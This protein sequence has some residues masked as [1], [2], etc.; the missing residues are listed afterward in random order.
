MDHSIGTITRVVISE[1]TQE[2]LD[3]LLAR[4]PGLGRALRWDS[5]VNSAIQREWTVNIAQRNALERLAHLICE[6]FLRLE[7][8][9]LTDGYSCEF[10][11][12][13]VDIADALGLTGI[14]VNRMLQQL[15]S[16]K[17]LTLKDRTLSIADM[18]ALRRLGG[19][20]PNYLYLSREAPATAP[21]ARSRGSI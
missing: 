18:E 1:F 17:L 6:L 7:R 10:P 21:T 8:V 19:F 20:N 14:H 12:T 15:R 4:A 2:V 3:D 9:G 13:Q 11:L 5:L 16:L